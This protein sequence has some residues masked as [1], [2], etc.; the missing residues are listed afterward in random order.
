MIKAMMMAMM[1]P[2]IKK[3]I[4]AMMMTMI[5]AL[6]RLMIKA[7]IKA[8]MKLIMKV[9]MKP[10]TKPATRAPTRGGGSGQQAMGVEVF[11][12]HDALETVPRLCQRL[13]GI[14]HLAR[15]KYNALQCITMQYNKAIK[16]N[17]IQC[18]KYN[19]MQQI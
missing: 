9:M 11:G 16:C 12:L 5:K 7:L 8:M 13:R 3:M 18:N 4:K 2:M 1:K 6:I 14:R 17:I 19:T 15:V 10:V